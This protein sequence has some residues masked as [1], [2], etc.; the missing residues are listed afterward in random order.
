MPDRGNTP[1]E[2]PREERGVRKGC[3]FFPPCAGQRR[4]T[5]APHKLSKRSAAPHGRLACH[6][7]CAGSSAPR[8]I[9]RHPIPN[10]E[11][12]LASL[13]SPR[14]DVLSRCLSRSRRHHPHPLSTRP[15]CAL[16]P[17]CTHA[18]ALLTSRVTTHG[19][20]TPRIGYHHHHHWPS[21]PSLSARGRSVRRARLLRAVSL[22]L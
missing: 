8:L 16:Q 12:P 18:S 9:H 10:P 19:H 20:W 15:P 17:A 14:G 13:A 3:D 11:T 6:V 5:S 4:S 2:L 7:A 22:R 1:T 21:P